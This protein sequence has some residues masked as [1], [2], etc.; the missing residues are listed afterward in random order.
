MK[1]CYRDGASFTPPNTLFATAVLFL[2]STAAETYLLRLGL[3]QKPTFGATF[4][5]R[6]AS[7]YQLVLLVF[8]VASRV[9]ANNA[10][11]RGSGLMNDDRQNRA[12]CRCLVGAVAGESGVV[13][14]CAGRA[15]ARGDGDLAGGVGGVGGVVVADV[16]EVVVDGDVFS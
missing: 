13:G 16:V 1:R 14:A 9:M 6:V 5:S 11:A 15:E 10:L 4:G 12:R 8:A 7:E 2:L 3:A